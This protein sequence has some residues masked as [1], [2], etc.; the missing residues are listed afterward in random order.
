MTLDDVFG[1]AFHA[2][3][4]DLEALTVRERILNFG[5]LFLVNLVQVNRQT[6][7]HQQLCESR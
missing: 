1:N 5:K 6:Y 3:D 4:L 2:K 7:G